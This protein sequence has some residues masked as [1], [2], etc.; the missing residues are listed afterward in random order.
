MPMG[1]LS[2]KAKG[3][4]RAVEPPPER[5][6]APVTERPVIIRFTEGVQDLHLALDTSDTVLTLKQKVH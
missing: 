2:E 4:Q 3:K 1:G 5:G 6:P